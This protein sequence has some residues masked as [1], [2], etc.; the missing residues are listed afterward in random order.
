MLHDVFLYI[1]ALAVG[2]QGCRRRRPPAMQ[3]TQKREGLLTECS[4]SAGKMWTPCFL[5]SGST[6]GPPAMRVSLLARQMSL[7]ALIAATVGC[8]PAHPAV[9]AAS[10]LITGLAPTQHNKHT[11]S[12][13]RASPVSSFAELKEPI[14]LGRCVSHPQHVH[15]TCAF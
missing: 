8:S 13:N 14:W 6:W 7:P 11:I 4:E 2:F 12:S 5:A 9:S 15:K 10:L 1:S 3:I